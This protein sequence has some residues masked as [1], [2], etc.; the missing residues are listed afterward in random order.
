MILLVVAHLLPLPSPARSL[1]LKSLKEG[2]PLDFEPMGVEASGGSRP[3][4][5]GSETENRGRETQLQ[6]Y[7]TRQ[8]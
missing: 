8:L 1:P 4:I 5:G 3:K 7:F 2:M 6:V